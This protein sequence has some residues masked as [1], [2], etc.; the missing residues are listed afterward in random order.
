MTAP[1][2]TRSAHA[3]RLFDGI[4]SSYGAPAEL[5][6]FGQYGRWR[7]A[8]V[9]RLDVPPGALVL[10]VATGTGLVAR[11][12]RRRRGARVVGLDQSAGMLDEARSRGETVVGASAVALPFADATFDGLAFTYLLRYVD[13]VPA[14]I[15]ELV[16]VL[17]PGAPMVSVEFGRPDGL[18]TGRLW[19]VYVLGAFPVAA[20]RLSP[21]WREVAAFL[22]PSV[23]SFSRRWPPERLANVW[24]DAGMAA[25]GIRTMSLGGGVVMWGRRGA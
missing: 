3:R 25:V 9:E 6:S 22:G 11:D 13:D 5:F 10:D 4:A 12:V 24:S 15:R 1:A 23:A 7:R 21:G 20:R 2:S 8:A 16:R 19:S 18:L 17:R 14:T